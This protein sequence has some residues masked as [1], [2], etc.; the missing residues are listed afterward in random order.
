M[1]DRRLYCFNKSYRPFPLTTLIKRLLLVCCLV[2]SGQPSW[3]RWSSEQR[4]DGANQ[5]G[6]RTGKP[7]IHLKLQNHGILGY[8]N[9]V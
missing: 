5:S 9:N 6:A 1:H 7:R 8:C 4:Q 2:K 3:R